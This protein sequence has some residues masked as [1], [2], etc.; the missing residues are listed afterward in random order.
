MLLDNNN[1]DLLISIEELCQQLQIGTST[2]YKL[3]QTGAIKSFKIGRIYKI[4]QESVYEYI[5]QQTK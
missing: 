2:A 4:P 3:L 1:S 5:K